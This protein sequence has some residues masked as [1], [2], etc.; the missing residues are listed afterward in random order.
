[1]SDSDVNKDE[2]NKR[3][4]KAMQRKKEHIDGRIAEATID[5]GLLVVAVWSCSVH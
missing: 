2:R 4:K 3:H 5:K 1:V